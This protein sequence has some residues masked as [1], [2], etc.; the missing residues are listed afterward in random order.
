MGRSH[1]FAIGFAAAWPEGEDHIKK[2]TTTNDRHFISGLNIPF[3]GSRIAVGV[4][5]RTNQEDEGRLSGNMIRDICSGKGHDVIDNLVAKVKAVA[6]EANVDIHRIQLRSLM[7][8]KSS[9]APTLVIELTELDDVLMGRII[10]HKVDHE[11]VPA[12]RSEIDSGTILKFTAWCKSQKQLR[13]IRQ[14]TGMLMDP[15]LKAHLAKSEAEQIL[16]QL[17]KEPGNRNAIMHSQWSNADLR[18]YSVDIPSSIESVQAYSGIIN[19]KI[20]L[21][22]NVVWETRRRTDGWAAI[23]L[24]Q[25]IPD[26]IA[27]SLVGKKLCEVI[28]HP[29]FDP[30]WEVVAIKKIP[31]VLTSGIRLHITCDPVPAM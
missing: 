13:D 7:P 21:A 26:S 9:F 1:P 10:T 16:T 8:T 27:H 18:G 12:G 22:S 25:D 24:I 28:E 5:G 3:A 29:L 14:E 23:E 2:I 19:A 15:F 31:P 11:D 17:R 6:K 4:A 20:R 30:S